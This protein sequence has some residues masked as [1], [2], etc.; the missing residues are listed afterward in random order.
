MPRPAKTDPALQVASITA[1]QAVIVA[2]ITSI[3]GL[4]GAWIANQH[5]SPEA[6]ERYIKITG[7]ES[8]T[9]GGAR[10]ILEV[11][12]QAY[13]YPSRAIW[14]IV[15][16][17]M[18]QESFPLPQGASSFSVHLAGF[19]DSAGDIRTLN[20]QEVQINA[21]SALPVQREFSLHQ[22]ESGAN[23]GLAVLRVKYM[24]Y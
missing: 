23:Q 18:S 4:L 10:I 14:A 22:V 16:S 19:F 20:T 5:K 3:A 24:I 2:L 17:N 1:K 7:V 13:S 11:N 8:S 21:L 15:S 12:G 9:P 6:I